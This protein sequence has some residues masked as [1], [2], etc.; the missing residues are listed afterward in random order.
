MKKTIVLSSILLATGLIYSCKKNISDKSPGNTVYLDLPAQPYAYYD[1]LMSG[2]STGLNKTATLG[3]VLFYD[4]HLSINNSIS[5][6]SCHKQ[7]LAFADNVALS[8]GFE[9]RLTGRNSM[10]IQNLGFS[11]TKTLNRVAGM[12]PL[13]WDGR[14]N[15]TAN[16]IA[17]PITNHVEMGISD[18]DKLV[19]KLS[20]LPY[21][22]ELFLAAYGSETITVEGIS[23]AVSTFMCSIRSTESRFDKSNQGA[24]GLNATEMK[25]LALFNNVYNCNN[26]HQPQNIGYMGKNMFNIGLEYPAKDKGAGAVSGN[27]ADVGSFKIPNLRNVALTAPYMHDGRFATLEDVLDYY[28]HG[29][30]NDPNLDENLRDKN[31]APLRLNITADDKKAII[32]FLNTLTDYSMTT[33]PKFSNP[34]KTK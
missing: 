28:S 32:A 9:N 27:P 22:K 11:S 5:C 24:N 34:F 7:Q 20:S 19:E 13:F 10:G 31:G 17:R 29:I 12:L 26:C 33:D 2:N 3:R 6:A 16:L 8:R 18:L 1:S 21:Y 15:S 14:E 23:D 4:N 25:G 30:P